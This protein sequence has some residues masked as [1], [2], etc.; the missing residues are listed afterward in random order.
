MK[1]PRDV[2]GVAAARALKR[3]GF[4]ELRQSGSHLIMRKETRTVVV[5]Q[6]KSLKPGTLKG[7]IEQAGSTLEQ[8][9]SEL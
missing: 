3:L 1:L 6:H 2:S 4:V 5:P 9:V 8:F 7:I